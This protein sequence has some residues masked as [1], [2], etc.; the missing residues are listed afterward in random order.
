MNSLS[1][2]VVGAGMGGL[3]A[4]AALRSVGLDVVVY[5]QAGTFGR[6]GAGIQQSPNA[7]KVLR[8]LGLEERL[9][10]I[11]F[12]PRMRRYR[13]AASGATLW[14]RLHEDKFERKYGAPHLL[15]HR[16]ELHAALLS[17]VPPEIIQRSKKLVDYR[18]ESSR[19]S[20]AFADGTT[21]S[22]DLMIAADGIHSIVREQMLGPEKP[23]FT[24]RV[25]YRTT[26]PAKLL[27]GLQLEDS[28]KWMS[29]DRHIVIYYVNP[30]K[31]ELYFVTSTP[32]ADFNV[33]SW[34]QEGDLDQLRAAYADFHPEV[35]AVLAACPKVHK[36]ALVERDPLP[37]WTD[38]RVALLGDACHP[39][40]PYMAQGA[41][42]SIEDAAILARC[43]EGVGSGGVAEALRL[44]ERT[45]KPRTSWI[46]AVSS[47]NDIV[48][49]RERQD[50]LYEY[51]AWT[52]PLAVR[53]MAS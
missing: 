42:T 46:Q 6:V 36:W 28:T 12:Q 1:V 30:R 47:S 9:R 5:E 45:R 19:V 8:R 50:E 25:A 22:A 21:A 13:E 23:R 53:S 44:Y 14:E 32:E 3:A 35:R 34:S 20:L 26:F 16:A 31:D 29:E 7:L 40:T 18:Q 49:M 39:M 51:D 27:G 52:A 41:A 10:E 15:L 2:A 37:T 43:L 33:E 17:I 38:G 24:G 11:A 48:Q 4:A